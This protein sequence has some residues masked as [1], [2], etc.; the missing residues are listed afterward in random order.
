MSHLWL[1]GQAHGEVGGE[2]DARV[3]I[4]RQTPILDMPKEWVVAVERLQLM[5]VKLP[6]FDPSSRTC[7]V[8]FRNKSTQA[9]TSLDVDFSPY[10]ES[11]SFIYD[12]KDVAKA[13]S[14][15]FSSL[16]STLSIAQ[17]PTMNFN[18]SSR[19][20]VISTVTAFINDWAIQFDDDLFSYLPSFF[21]RMSYCEGKSDLGG[22]EV[23]GWGWNEKE[24][25]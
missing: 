7:T 22:C 13:I 15:C 5:N 25:E 20:F 14:T 9:I 4:N 18:N 1:S 8:N 10:Q 12:L 2:R 3:I 17:V 16:C 23:G 11:D 24:K 21:V 6:L 19:H